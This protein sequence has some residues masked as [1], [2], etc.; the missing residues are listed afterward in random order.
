MPLAN[1]WR[2]T[3]VQRSRPV[4]LGDL[5][6]QLD[7]LHARYEELREESDHEDL[8]GGDASTRREVGRF[9][10]RAVAAADRLLPRPSTYRNEADATIATFQDHSGGFMNPGGLALALLG[11]LDAFRED[12]EAG[13]LAEIEAAINSGVFADFLDMA[14]HVLSEIHKT[15][16][17]VIA[18]FTLEEHLRKLCARAGIAT[19]R[20]DGQPVKADSMNAELANASTYSKTEQKD[21]LAWLGRRNDAAHGKHDEYTD[22]QVEL[23]IEG[24][25]GFVSRHPA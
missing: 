20:S 18:G 7:A 2:R 11:V 19:T 25:R 23:M 3:V 1:D 21:V 12:A 22:D 14:D 10:T 17:A 9:C 6:E 15:P 13:Y 16:A 5:A 8:S 4:D 24:V